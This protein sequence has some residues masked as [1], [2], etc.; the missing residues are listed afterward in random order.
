ML[1]N[2]DPISGGL[3]GNQTVTTAGRNFSW[4]R[5]NANAVKVASLLGDGTRFTAYRY[6]VGSTLVGA[7]KAA[8]R[9]TGFFAGDDVSSAFTAS[10]WSLFDAA[11]RWTAGQ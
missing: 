5:P 2:N 8:E 6:E 9:R 11:V 4:G 3:S 1:S 7:S 10:G